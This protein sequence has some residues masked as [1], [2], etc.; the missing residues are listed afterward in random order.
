MTTMFSL[1]VFSTPAHAYVDPGTGSAIMTVLIGLAVS[2]G[3]LVKT[4][5]YKILVILKIKPPISDDSDN[6]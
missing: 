1:V 2:A 6:E 4:F 3:V 5:W